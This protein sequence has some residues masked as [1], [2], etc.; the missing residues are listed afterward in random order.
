MLEGKHRFRLGI[1][2]Y[3][4][5]T[6]ILPNVKAFAPF[7]DDFELTLFE[8]ESSSLPSP[9][10]VAQLVR[11]AKDNEL[12]YTVHFPLDRRLGSELFAER[13]A[14]QQSILAIMRRVRPLKPF[15]WILHLE[16]IAPQ[17]SARKR[18]AWSKRI[19]GLLP[20]I[21]AQAE[22][23][24]LICVENLLYPFEWCVE[25]VESFKLGVCIDIG[26]LL[27]LGEDV[28]LHLRRFL[29]R[30]RIIHLHGMSGGKDH[31]ALDAIPAGDLRRY[32]AAMADFR[33]VLTLELFNLPDVAASIK[34]L[35]RCL[36]MP[37][38]S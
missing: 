2:S 25:M 27:S 32:L 33:G 10:T 16:G 1:P 7:V 34:Y 36:A 24:G 38:C 20:D 9:E 21:I 13:K 17:A 15:A 28:R 22:N 30:A 5:P 6:D 31:R 26:H 8:S 4:L 18:Q 35:G 29:P 3:V 11:L 12:S 37:D 23:P 19:A 14:M